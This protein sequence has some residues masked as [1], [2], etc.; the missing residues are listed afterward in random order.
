[1][2]SSTGGANRITCSGNEICVVSSARLEWN[3]HS[4]L[5]RGDS[6]VR[7]GESRQHEQNAELRSHVTP[8]RSSE[9]AHGPASFGRIA[10]DVTALEHAPVLVRSWQTSGQVSVRNFFITSDLRGNVIAVALERASGIWHDVCR[11]T[12]T[13]N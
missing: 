13:V 7:S 6:G 9:R 4:A 5:I 3:V 12:E 2:R 8:R 10:I 1:L 11:R